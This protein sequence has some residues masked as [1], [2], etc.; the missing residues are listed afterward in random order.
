[1]TT[2]VRRAMRVARTDLPASIVVFLVALPLCAGVAVASGVPAE[3]GLVTGVVGGLVAGA[4]PGS[5]LQ[6]SGPAAGLTAL[7]AEAVDAYG[8]AALG[9]I[10]LVAGLLQ[11]G[12]GALRVGRWFQAISVAVVQGMLTG[13]GLL[14]IAAQLY[15]LA[16]ATAP[17]SG[18]DKLAG[19]VRLAARAATSST[20]LTA[21]AVGLGTIVIAVRWAQLPGPARLVPGML[22]AVT[23]ASAATAVLDLPLATVD[24]GGL[25]SVLQPSIGQLRQLADVGV[26]GT[27]VAFALVASAESLFSASAV[28]RMHHGSR[29][30]F[31]KELVAQG[32][33]NSVCGVLGSLP[34]TAVIVRS[35]A[36]VQA[37]ARTKAS[38]VL[39]GVW[40]LVFVAALPAVLGLIPLP[41]LAGV[42][43]HAGFKLLPVKVLPQLWREHRGEALVLAGTAGAILLIDM[44]QGVLIGLGLAVA[45]SAWATSHVRVHVTDPGRG[46]IHVRLVGNATFLRLPVILTAL[47]ALPA[48]RAVQLDLRGL[49][50]VDHACQTALSSWA[51]RHNSTAPTPVLLLAGGHDPP[52]A[53][54]R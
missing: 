50:H 30:A 23:A 54:G 32:I 41:A 15:V 7:V 16:G 10:V 51:D 5:S 38:R 53:S 22:V 28:D 31:D 49:R 9:P 29:T 25:L 44:F 35:A 12:L 43:I 21:V 33:G 46:P 13:I 3:L 27:A 2:P 37:G 18:I 24:V 4:L 14:L 17:S 20:A 1:M 42:L 26:L 11:I 19:L 39:H 36:N 6:V 48:H 8:V 47:S 34:M 52:S 40:L 45:K